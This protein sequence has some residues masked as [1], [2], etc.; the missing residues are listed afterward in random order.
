MRKTD[1]TPHLCSYCIRLLRTA[2]RY[3]GCL[4]L[5]LSLSGQT[6]AQSLN[7]R[8][9]VTDA[10]SKTF[11]PDVTVTSGSSS[12]KTDSSGKF[13]LDVQ[14][15]TLKQV[16]LRFTHVSYRPQLIAYDPSDNYQVRMKTSFIELPEVKVMGSGLSLLEKAIKR[17]PQNYPD[18]VAMLTG[19]IRL[20]YLRNGTDHFNSDAMVQLYIPPV[21][22]GRESAARLVTNRTS[23]L[24]DPSLIFI[25]WIGAYRAPLHAD[26]VGKKAAFIDPKKIRTYQYQL[27]GKRRLGG[28][29]VFAINFA[30]HDTSGK[31]EATA[32]TLFIDSTTFAFA[33]AD[34]SYYHLKR[35]GVLPRSKVQYSVRYRKLG[36]KWYL[37]EAFTKGNTI[38]KKEDPVSLT[39]YVTT[40]IDTENVTPFSYADIIQETDVTQRIRKPTDTTL[41]NGVDSMLQQTLRYQELY[42]V[43][44]LATAR[45]D[46]RKKERKGRNWLN[47]FTG[48]NTRAGISVMRF[49]LNH[50]SSSGPV[51]YGFQLGAHYRLY[52]G[53][54]LGFEGAGNIGTNTALSLY[55]FRASYEFTVTSISGRSVIL[56]PFVGYNILTINEKNR[57]LKSQANYWSYGS[58]VAFELTHQIFLSATLTVADLSLKG[59]GSFRPTTVSP[60][61][62][63][64]IKR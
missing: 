12:T 51:N 29:T 48:D 13:S 56:T 47:Y 58:A 33:G 14:L 1:H 54:F 63:L 36:S 10:D 31:K 53:L 26:F 4:C 52:Q 15:T 43:A 49:P 27:A 45:T 3:I 5:V 34:I 57:S 16:G 18:K 7:V 50:N 11:L 42:P 8:G 17:I 25:K 30:H 35:Y 40:K 62:G 32:G 9:R 61:L 19:F 46:A 28:R 39:D 38:Y 23:T 60:A 59:T 2:P 37:Q 44:E 6:L 64:M 20:Q 22:R 55:H 41:L 24:T 21:G